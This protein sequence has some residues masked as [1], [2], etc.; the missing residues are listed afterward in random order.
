MRTEDREGGE[1]IIK[2]KCGS[3]AIN[4]HMHGRV[5]GVDLGLCDVCYWRKRAEAYRAA[6]TALMPF[7]MEDY[8]DDKYGCLDLERKAAIELAIAASNT[9][10]KDVTR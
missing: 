4:D 8:E 3:Y 2:C 1:V 10:A 9:E 5:R 6:I 7:L